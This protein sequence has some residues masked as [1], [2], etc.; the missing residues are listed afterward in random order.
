ML[1][2]QI[3]ALLLLAVSCV[4]VSRDCRNCIELFQDSLPK[5]P[6]ALRHQKTIIYRLRYACLSFP[7]KAETKCLRFLMTNS[8]IGVTY[9]ID[10]KLRYL[11]EEI[12][13][14]HSDMCESCIHAVEIVQPLLDMTKHS[15]TS[16]FISIMCTLLEPFVEKKQ[17]GKLL[18][19]EMHYVERFF[20]EQPNGYPFCKTFRFCS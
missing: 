2:L 11:C 10:N 15:R 20:H 19:E 13:L 12:Q 16:D 18:Q 3:V 9:A 14:C 8:S 5:H 6:L 1:H 4:S 17:C 7:A